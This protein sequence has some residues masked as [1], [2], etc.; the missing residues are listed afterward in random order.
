MPSGTSAWHYVETR[1]Y[2]ETRQG[3]DNLAGTQPQAFGNGA[4]KE[5]YHT[6]TGFASNHS[7]NHL[8]TTYFPKPAHL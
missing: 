7:T 3:S 5:H 4:F 8:T 2:M 1:H 6:T